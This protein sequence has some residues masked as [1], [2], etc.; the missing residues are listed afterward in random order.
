M[1]APAAVAGSAATIRLVLGLWCCSG[2]GGDDL[3]DFLDQR[4]KK[5]QAQELLSFSRHDPLNV[6]RTGQGTVIIHGLP[7]LGD[8]ILGKHFS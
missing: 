7:N 8:K 6:A 4:G 2:N 5:S 3:P 1:S